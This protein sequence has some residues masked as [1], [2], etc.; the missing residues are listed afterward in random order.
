MS[1]WSWSIPVSVNE[2]FSPEPSSPMELFANSGMPTIAPA[3][4]LVTRNSYAGSDQIIL[5]SLASDS[6]LI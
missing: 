2:I 3:T 4:A 1:G 5:P 6:K